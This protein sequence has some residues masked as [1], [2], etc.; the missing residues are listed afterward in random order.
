MKCPKCKA[1]LLPVDGELF[2]LQC[3]TA[4][5]ASPITRSDAEGPALEDT[6]DPV[7][8]KA[9]TDSTH[10]PVHFRLPVSEAQ[11][12][13]AT[14]AFTSMH[15]VFTTPAP[16]KSGKIQQHSVAGEPS[17]EERV[18]TGTRKPPEAS[19]GRLAMPHISATW[20]VGFVVFAAFVGLNI[21]AASLWQGRT[22]PGVKVGSSSVGS[23]SA[24]QVRGVIKGMPRPAL[25][26]VVN[27]IAYPT[28]AGL[29]DSADI[30]R[31]TSS[32]LHIGRSTPIPL[33]GLLQALMSSPVEIDYSLNASHLAAYADSLKQ[34]IDTTAAPAAPIVVGDQIIVLPDKPGVR[35]D[36]TQLIS[37]IKAAYGHQPQV[38]VSAEEVKP[39]LSAS[40]Y[41]SD[42]AAAK[43]VI[44]SDLKVV[45]KSS[46][47]SPDAST[48]ASWI[49]FATPG[50]GVSVDPGAIGAYLN[51]LPGSFDRVGAQAALIAAAS[52][53]I[54]TSYSASTKKNSQAFAVVVKPG[55][56]T[57]AYC[58]DSASKNAMASVASA[59]SLGGAIRFV[60]AGQCNVHSMV[61]DSQL[62]TAL[63]GECAIYASCHTESALLFESRMWT[64]A[65]APWAASSTDYQH[66][67]AVHELGH[68]IGF[69]HAP[70]TNGASQQPVLSAG[71]VTVAGCSPAWYVVPSDTI[72]KRQWNGLQKR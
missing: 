68:W 30:D 18:V 60:E 35:I 13:A 19:R 53:G 71:T 39:L 47:Y 20:L 22:F 26:V 63:G 34:Q 41:A 70:C 50:S 16:A 56:V 11:P 37:G 21:L 9:I 32:A 25:K 36:R 62:M 1:K 51:G 43:A 28:D 40:A 45:V 10:H 54:N 5:H 65:S 38:A 64:T 8:Q 2:C 4:V 23:M 69:D 27:N 66:E 31:A 14:T 6:T 55:P 52:K 12:V 42:Q 15:R 57:Y 49:R 33:L 59:W 29:Q 3:G 17:M 58:T 48:K 67:L 44:S 61:A 7:L 46:S 24:D 72:A